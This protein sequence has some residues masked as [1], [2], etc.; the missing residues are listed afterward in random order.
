MQNNEEIKTT[1]WSID[2]LCDNDKCNYSE[3]KLYMPREEI[4]DMFTDHF[5]PMCGGIL[6][7]SDIGKDNSQRDRWRD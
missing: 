1:P 2:Y 4:L 7:K 3:N 6:R 5:C